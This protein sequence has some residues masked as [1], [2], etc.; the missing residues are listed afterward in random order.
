MDFPKSLDLNRLRSLLSPQVDDAALHAALDRLRQ[1]APPPVLWLF[2]KVQS[3][4][5]S[6]VRALTGAERAQIGDGFRPCTRT[7]ARYEFPNADFP[8]AVFLDT[9]GVGEAGY[10]P[11]ED[12]AAFQAQAHLILVVVKAMDMA[13]EQVLIALKHLLRA[14]PTW[15]VVVAQTTLHEGY[16][17]TLRDHLMPYSFAGQSIPDSVPR[18]LTRALL[19]Q[20]QLF[21]G[22]SVKSFVPLD[23]TLP[24]DG[25]SEPFYGR[26]A[27][28]QAVAEAHPHTVYAMLRQLPEFTRELK[29]LHFR[30]AQPHILAYA[31]AA[32]VVAAA[33][34]PLAD[35]PVISALQLKMLHTVASLYR[36]PL[37]VKTFLE[38]I[39]T[40]GLGMLFRQGARSLL[41]VVPGFG[42][43][44][45]SLYAGAATYALGCALCFYYQVVFDGHVP[46]PERLKTFYEEKFAEGLEML[47]KSASGSRK[48]V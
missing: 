23:F 24:E 20:R 12:L 4:K 40:V 44:L 48:S 1:G 5:T 47:K 13:L 29:T 7:A 42:H 2:G 34:L 37:G 45:S 35:L 11:Q 36:Q 19:F 17:A 33:P 8:L 25:F 21:A 43:A 31:T 39:S 30:R 32:A 9:R 3:G 46:T 26:E 27:L 41:K 22:L 15:P 18:D 16:P 6:I 14:N 38:L 28:L 10:D